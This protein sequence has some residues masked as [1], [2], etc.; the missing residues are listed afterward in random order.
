MALLLSVTATEKWELENKIKM[1]RT[2]NHSSGCAKS[3]AP[4]T[5]PLAMKG[6][7][8]KPPKKIPKALNPEIWKEIAPVWFNW[9]RW[10]LT[11]GAIGYVAQRT[12]NLGLQIIYGVSHVVFYMFIT[13]TIADLMKMRVFKNITLN[14]IVTLCLALVV[15]LATRLVL[16]QSIRELL[17]G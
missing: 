17:K 16:D 1:Q 8:V 2:T 12:Q 7:N 6:K 13:T 3:R 15:L 11:L 10:F 5:L 4:L 9:L 14:S